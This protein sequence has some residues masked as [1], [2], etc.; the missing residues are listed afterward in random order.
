MAGTSG[1]SGGARAGAGR[2]KKKQQFNTQITRVNRK[3]AKGLDGYL[4]KLEALANG[5]EVEEHWYE[6]ACTIHVETDLDILGEDGKPTGKTRRV[7]RLAFPDK[8]P[9]EMVLVRKKAVTLAPD[10]RAL[11]YLFNRLIGAPPVEDEDEDE[12]EATDSLPDALEAAIAKAYST[13]EGETGADDGR[14]A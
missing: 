14:T 13:A 1:R 2:P 9:D 7:K 5:A 10:V 6:A 11:I 8:E 12:E 4:L 3:I